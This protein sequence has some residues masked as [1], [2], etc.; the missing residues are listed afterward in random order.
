MALTFGSVFTGI[1]GFDLALERAGMAC[2]WQVE[3]EPHCCQVLRRHWPQVARWRDVRDVGGTDLAAVDLLAGGFPCQDLSVA[4][5]RAGLDGA[6]SGLFYE[7]ARLAAELRPSWVVVENVAGLLSSNG[8]RDMGTVLGT[9]AE[10]GYRGGYRVLDA[11]YFGVAQRRKRVFLVFHAGDG[12]RAVQVLFEPESLP[13][14]PAPRREEGEGL[15]VAPGGRAGPRGVAPDVDRMTFVPETAGTLLGG[16]AH[17]DAHGKPNGSDRV[18]LLAHPG[19]AYAVTGA[20][21]KFGSGRHNQD[22]FVAFIDAYACRGSS[23][24]NQSPVKMDGLSD[25]LDTT[26]PGAVAFSCKDDGRDVGEIAPTLR[27][28]SHDRSHPNGGGQIAI[29]RGMAVRRL[30]PRECERLQGFPDDWTAWGVDERGQRVEIADSHRYRMCGNAVCVPVVEWLA[31][32]IVV[33][34]AATRRRYDAA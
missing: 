17:G 24:P 3:I 11:E 4:G 1:G 9:L 27:S 31:R 19:P 16:A 13:G 30:T 21:S 15:A 23:S 28:L 6:R 29:Q 22:T 7:F 34:A 32:R 18:T 12:S 14:D 10:L 26:G 20:G 5:R 2:S 25:A 8:G 33:A